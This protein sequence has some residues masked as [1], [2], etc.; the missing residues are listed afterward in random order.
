M[1]A[2]IAGYITNNQTILERE[3]LETL[4]KEVFQLNSYK[5]LESSS[6]FLTLFLKKRY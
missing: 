3:H 5:H 2:K 4:A 1:N 6:H